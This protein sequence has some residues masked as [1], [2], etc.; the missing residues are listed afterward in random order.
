MSS[1]EKPVEWSGWPRSQ[2]VTH[3]ELTHKRSQL[4]GMLRNEIGSDR[5]TDRLDKSELAH[6]CLKSGVIPCR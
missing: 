5:D 3:I 1:F 2:K 4:M 6:L